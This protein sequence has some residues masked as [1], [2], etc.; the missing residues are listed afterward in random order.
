[1]LQNF[2]L[3]TAFAAFH[4]F[5][6]VSFSFAS[7]NFFIS[8][9]IHWLFRRVLSNFCMLVNSPAF[10]SLSIPS[11]MPLWPDK[12]PGLI[13]VFLNVWDGASGLSSSLPEDLNQAGVFPEFSSR[14]RHWFCSAVRRGH[15][16]TLSFSAIAGRAAGWAT[17]L[18]MSSEQ[19]LSLDRLKAAFSAEQGHRLDSLPRSRGRSCYKASKVLCC[20]NLRPTSW[21]VAGPHSFELLLTVLLVRRS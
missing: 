8:Y 2:P 7:R 1:M 15:G 9:S 6:Y 11:F 5:Q 3:R 17:R 13:S 18:P 14:V 19:V 20:L 12:I 21:G 16:C 4:K 10:L